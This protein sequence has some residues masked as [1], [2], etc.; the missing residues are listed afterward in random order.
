MTEPDQ[1][2]DGTY[3]PSVAL[4]AIFLG[5]YLCDLETD[6][7]RNGRMRTAVGDQIA[8]YHEA[9]ADDANAPTLPETP[10]TAALLATLPKD[11]PLDVRTT[12]LIDLLFTLPFSPAELK[13]KDA[14]RVDALYQVADHIGIGNQI[15]DELRELQESATKAHRHVKVGKIAFMAGGGMLLLALTAGAAAPFVAGAIGAAAGLA[16]AAALAHGLAVLGLGSLA[17][18]GFGM[19]GGIWIV[20]GAGAVVGALGGS[21]AGALVQLGPVT[22]RQELIK[23]QVT[24]VAVG[25]NLAKR[26][27]I[28][29]AEQHSQSHSPSHVL[30]KLAS[31]RDEVRAR[32]DDALKRNEDDA[33][34]VEDLRAIEQAMTDAMTWISEQITAA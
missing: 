8:A 19:A 24:T 20:T 13:F 11:W 1:A 26:E 7:D 2:F 14:K 23:L 30:G 15:V 21:A 33:H 34:V 31:E 17:A 32:I 29:R 6:L 10:T 18:G 27:Q 16:G 25:I 9:F 4:G 5:S 22:A 3:G 28:L 12:F